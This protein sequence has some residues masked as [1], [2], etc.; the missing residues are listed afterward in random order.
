MKSPP[1]LLRGSMIN[2][3]SATEIEDMRCS[4]RILSG[5]LIKLSQMIKPGIT[6][7]E[8][9]QEAVKYF[10]ANNVRSN[11]KNYHGFPN[12]ICVS[13]N[14][15]LIHGIPNHQPFKSGDIVSVDA[16]CIYNGMH[17]DAAFSMIAGR[18]RCDQDE[19]LVNATKQSLIQAINVMGPNINIGT[20]GATIQKYITN[21]GFYLTDKFAGHG[22][23]KEMHQDPLIPNVG[24]TN[25]GQRLH[26]GMVVC[27]EP[28]VQTKDPRVKSKRDGWTIT[29]TSQGMA[30]HYEAMILITDTGC[31]VLTTII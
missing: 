4:A 26:P 16:G 1:T 9:D 5:L 27:I 7:M 22:I 19:K 13:V 21:Q 12:T 3:L 29:T 24:K 14:S 17:S 30:A 31:E 20:I 10:K 28:M 2:L 18:R 8:L 25:A 15:D 23:G 11:F 6:G